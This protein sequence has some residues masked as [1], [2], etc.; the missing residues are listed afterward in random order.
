MASRVKMGFYLL[1]INLY[2][3]IISI[4]TKKTS[5]LKIGSFKFLV[6]Y[7]IVLGMLLV[8]AILWQ[9][10]LKRV[11]LS[12]AF[13]FK[14]SSIIFIMIISYVVF[15]EKITLYNILGCLIIGVGITLMFKGE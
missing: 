10:I 11:E 9:Q 7:G 1:S 8:Y 2:Y 13:M 12:T 3:S 15:Y 5:E 4:A 14:G 6:G